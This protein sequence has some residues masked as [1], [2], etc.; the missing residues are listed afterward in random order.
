MALPRLSKSTGRGRRSSSSRFLFQ[1]VRS[2]LQFVSVMRQAEVLIKHVSA[3]RRV[4][5]YHASSRGQQQSLD[6]RMT[7]FPQAGKSLV[8]PK[9]LSGDPRAR[10]HVWQ[11]LPVEGADP[12]RVGS[13]LFPSLSLAAPPPARRVGL[14]QPMARC[15]SPRCRGSSRARRPRGCGQTSTWELSGSTQGF[16]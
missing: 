6:T 16:P 11:T 14:K 3:N 13:L 12:A 15:T 1:N 5:G 8:R 10:P 2:Q 9:R 4:I 7:A